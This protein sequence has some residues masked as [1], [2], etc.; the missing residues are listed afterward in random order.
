M[1]DETMGSACWYNGHPVLAAN[2]NVKYR[3]SVPLGQSYICVAHLERVES[4]RA[5]VKA[6]IFDEGQTYVEAKGLFIR[7]PVELL[8]KQPDMAQMAEIIETLKS[9][10]SLNDLIELDKKRK[11]TSWQ[12]NEGLD[13]LISRG[14]DLLN[15]AV[16]FAMQALVPDKQQNQ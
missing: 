2:L 3:K 12:K 15:D 7:V 14:V 13:Q 4:R 16:S 9:G 8:K 10:K 1:L 11:G 5:I 6:R